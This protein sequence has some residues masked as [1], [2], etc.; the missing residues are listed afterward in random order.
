MNKQSTLRDMVAR[1]DEVTGHPGLAQPPR[2]G[3]PQRDAINAIIDGGVTE[4]CGRI[5]DLMNKLKD[6]QQQ[7]IDRAAD[8]KA[9]LNET[10]SVCIKINDEIAH[11]SAVIDEIAARG[12]DE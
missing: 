8:A 10:V 5:G 3:E 11:T 1:L 4:L 9:M 6:L 7:A 12:R 2:P